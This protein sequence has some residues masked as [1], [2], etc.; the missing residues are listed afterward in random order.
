VGTWSWKWRRRRREGR[1]IGGSGTCLSCNERCERN[2]VNDSAAGTRDDGKVERLTF[3]GLVVAGTEDKVGVWVLVQQRLDDLALID[4][5]RS[6]LEVLLSD[7][8]LDRTTGSDVLQ[9]VVAL[10]AL[11]RAEKVETRKENISN[12]SGKRLFS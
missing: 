1:W 5:Q 12:R 7:E 2:G 10:L 9:Q 3:I 4:G 6:D 8:D 11:E